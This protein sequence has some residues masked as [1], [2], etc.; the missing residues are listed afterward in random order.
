[1]NQ[2]SNNHHSKALFLFT[3]LAYFSKAVQRVGRVWLVLKFS[4]LHEGLF[5][6]L[7]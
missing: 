3:K 1:M 4:K 5:G 6:L 2:V 7:T